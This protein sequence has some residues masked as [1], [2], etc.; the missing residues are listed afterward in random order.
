MEGIRPLGET[1]QGTPTSRVS[2][3]AV[4]PVDALVVLAIVAAP[5]TGGGSLALLAF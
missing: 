2:G 1:L 3:W 5:E 4:V